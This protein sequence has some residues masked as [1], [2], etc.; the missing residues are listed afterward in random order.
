MMNMKWTDVAEPLYKPSV[1][2]ARYIDFYNKMDIG[3]DEFMKMIT[4]RERLVR[5]PI[6][7]FRRWWYV[8]KLFTLT[9]LLDGKPI[10]RK[11]FWK[12]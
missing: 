3:F 7:S 12:F 8:P 6:K 2:Y 4:D 10:V 5:P 11:I 1:K 9:G